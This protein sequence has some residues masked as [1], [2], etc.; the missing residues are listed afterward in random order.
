MSNGKRVFALAFRRWLVEQARQPGASVAGLGLRHGINANQLR[1]WMLVDHKLTQ[2][3]SGVALLAVHIEDR[4]ALPMVAASASA[5]ASMPLPSSEPTAM[6]APRRAGHIELEVFGARLRLH[7][8]VDA[9]Q[10]RVV[11]D[12][13]AKRP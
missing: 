2:G 1:R 3:A 4:Q 7:G 9:Q 6:P 13:L 5:S 8:D 11:L 12:A 10:L